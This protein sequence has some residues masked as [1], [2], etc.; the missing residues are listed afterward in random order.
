MVRAHSTHVQTS[1][2]APIGVFQLHS[3]VFDGDA[4]DPYNCTAEVLVT[5]GAGVSDAQLAATLAAGVDI[6]AGSLGYDAPDV[7][8]S[9]LVTIRG[10]G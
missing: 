2:F 8:R 5:V 6:A 3:V 7:V 4:V 1:F 9:G 10:E